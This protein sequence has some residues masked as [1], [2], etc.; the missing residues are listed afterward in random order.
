[1][2]ATCWLSGLAGRFPAGAGAVEAVAAVGGRVEPLPEGGA[3][4]LVVVVDAETS[5]EAGEVV[6]VAEFGSIGAIHG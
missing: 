4:R 1:M 6:H 5:A 3:E 2:S